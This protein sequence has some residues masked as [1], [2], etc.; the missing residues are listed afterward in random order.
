MDDIVLQ[1][2][3][4]LIHM[5]A[6]LDEEELLLEPLVN[7]NP[8]DQGRALAQIGKVADARAELEKANAAMLLALRVRADA[9]PVDEAAG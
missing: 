6:T 7:A 4:R 2:R 1:A 3:I 8:P 9:G 5:K